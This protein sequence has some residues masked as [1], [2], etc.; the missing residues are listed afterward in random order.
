MYVVQVCLIK[1]QV[2]G[3]K[4]ISSHARNLC[5]WKTHVFDFAQ[6]PQEVLLMD[7]LCY[8]GG[9]KFYPGGMCRQIFI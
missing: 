2:P 9:V 6:A 1:R 8:R 3:E 5:V 7:R 4:V